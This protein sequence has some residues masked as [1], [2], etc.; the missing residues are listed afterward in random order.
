MQNTNFMIQHHVTHLGDICKLY[1]K[2]TEL[3]YSILKWEG[4]EK[5]L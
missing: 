4:P 1:Q 3:G 5:A 2:K